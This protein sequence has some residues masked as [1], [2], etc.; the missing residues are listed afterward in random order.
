M[1]VSNVG[2][3]RPKHSPAWV[4]CSERLPVEGAKYYLLL[5]CVNGD[6]SY[7]SKGVAWEDGEEVRVPRLIQATDAV[8]FYR[9]RD[10]AC[11]VLEDSAEF[12]IWLLHWGGHAVVKKEVWDMF[13]TE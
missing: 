10:V 2:A 3:L 1:T 6:V 13:D 11:L 4:E 8:M 12:S 5:G 7:Y 9:K